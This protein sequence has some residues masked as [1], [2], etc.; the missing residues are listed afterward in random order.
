MSL[1]R[2]RF[3]VITGVSG[4]GK[5]SLAFDTIFAEGQRRYI[6]ALSAQ[7]RLFLRRLDAPSIDEIIGLS[8]AIAV[9]QK[10]MSANPRST[11]GTLTE[12]SDFLRIL[13]S[14]LGVMHCPACGIPVRSHTIPEMAQE[15][16]D[17]WPSGAKLLVLS[18]SV[19]VKE[20]FL[21][22]ALR[23][24]RKDGYARVRIDGKIYELDPL[25]QIPRRASYSIE[26]VVDRLIL[27]SEKLKRLLS[28]LELASQL[29]KGELT[30]VCIDHG[31]KPFS[32]LFRC[33]SCGMDLPRP[34]PGLF[35]FLS[36][37]GA[38]PGCNGLGLR[39]ASSLAGGEKPASRSPIPG[40][41]D[42]S[43]NSADTP[44]IRE[45]SSHQAHHSTRIECPEC[46]GARLNLLSRS[47]RLGGLGLH[48][49]SNMP[50]PSVRIW[51]EKLTLSPSQ[52]LIASRPRQEILRRLDL[53]HEL[54]LPYLSLNRSCLTLSGGEFQRIRIAQQIG[55][56]LSGVIYVLDEPSMGLHP[57]DHAQLLK[58][59]FHLRD[60][61][62]TVIVVEHDRDTI[63]QSDFVVD[64]GPGAGKHGG[65]LIFAGSPQELL[66]CLNSRTAS[67]L[68]GRRR[69]SFA[70]KRKVFSKGEIRII[71][72]RGHNLKD[73]TARFPIGCITCVT[74]V[75]GSGKSTLVMHTLYRAIAKELYGAATLPAPFDRIEGIGS[76]RRVILADQTPIGRTPR[77]TP[78][79]YTGLFSL[80]RDLFARL[81]EAK[82]RGY[83]S[84]RFSYNAKGGRCESCK[85]EGLQRI[86]MHFLP[87]VHVVCPVCKGKR[88]N[89]ETLDVL[90]KGLS[91]ADVLSMS[92]HDAAAF[93]ES[94]PQI[95]SKL[96]AL[97]EVGLGYL[98]LGQPASTLS[99]GEAQRVK[100]ASE[101]SRSVNDMGLYLFDEPT[102]GLHFEDIEKLLHVLQR[103]ADA[104]HTVIMIEHH[105]DV[106][107][108]S[109]FVLDLGPEG[110]EEGGYIVAS[111]TSEEIALERGSHTGRF[112]QR[113][114]F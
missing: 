4:S 33:T 90:Y 76:I 30:V 114:V 43:H 58:T 66:E 105:P 35:S 7:A 9:E 19:A 85:G 74:G 91:I 47:V 111:G 104:G 95:R 8:P 97:Q 113:Q 36:P 69:I 2:N 64:I 109:D 16:S 45:P 57:R 32:E 18:R 22:S 29:G 83:D 26:V 112:L 108:S 1:P 72:A 15:I 73:I 79:T 41:E 25:P 65:E 38:C 87:P 52:E 99:G 42:L 102:T 50:L 59:I 96:S 86:E 81:P 82:A 106:I 100:L 24:I 94:I 56:R 28:S 6:E 11:V 61:G 27:D 98:C 31:E 107:R 13:Y 63:L 89:D 14:K 54:G 75:S 12:I 92:V 49:V 67:Y 51:L 48:D 80:I 17:L 88:Y 3:I 101:L 60:S 23:G 5:S 21:S 84:R 37:V 103:L 110:G 68:S 78:A 53:L 55:A 44:S 71:G 20:R 40:F 77:S 70:S 93:F 62:N 39:T 10:G 34:T 46:N